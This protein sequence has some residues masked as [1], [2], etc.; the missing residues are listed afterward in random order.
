LERSSLN[1]LDQMDLFDRK[2]DVPVAQLDRAFA[3][4]AKGREFESPQG[5]LQSGFPALLFY[6]VGFK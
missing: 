4:G 3:C 1:L 2:N 5:R 6:G